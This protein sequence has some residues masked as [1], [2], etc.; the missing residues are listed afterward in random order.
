MLKVI[1]FKKIKKNVSIVQLKSE[2]KVEIRGSWD[3][4]NSENR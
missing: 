3:L 4:R 1:K 2:P